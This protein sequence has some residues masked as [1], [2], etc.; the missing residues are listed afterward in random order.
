MK[1]V[2]V[3]L[4]GLLI[5]C[6]LL[7]LRKGIERL[8]CSSLRKQAII[9]YLA[10]IFGLALLFLVWQPEEGENQEMLPPPSILEVF[11]QG[12]DIQALAPYKVETWS[13]ALEG[14]VLRLEAIRSNLG[15]P[16]KIPV[17]LIE[18]DQGKGQVTLYRTPSHL[19][20]QEVASEAFLPSIE[21]E[22]N[23]VM[24]KLRD[25]PLTYEIRTIRHSLF[26]QPFVEGDPV[27]IHDLAVGEIGLVIEVPKATAIM[28]DSNV[29]LLFRH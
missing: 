2:T 9:I 4:L 21:V 19:M 18:K 25:G 15:I 24:A 5:L 28:A 6:F 14:E 1:L 27:D 20:Q 12:S 11:F 26:L 13:L 17:L 3:F 10:S 8:L 22:D 16:V 7:F 23:K 29:F